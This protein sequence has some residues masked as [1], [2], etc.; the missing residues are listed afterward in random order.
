MKKLILIFSLL[1]IL[2]MASCESPEG[3]AKITKEQLKKPPAE[4]TNGSLHSKS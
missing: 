3:T 2:I 4:E 1:F